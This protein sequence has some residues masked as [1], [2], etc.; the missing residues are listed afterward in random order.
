[1]DSEQQG[2]TSIAGSLMCAEKTDLH[3]GRPAFHKLIELK[4]AKYVERAAVIGGGGFAV[5]HL[6]SSQRLCGPV[7]ATIPDEVGHEY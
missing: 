6:H 4:V 2:A 3:S 5:P 7:I 1:M